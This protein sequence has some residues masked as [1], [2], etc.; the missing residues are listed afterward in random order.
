MAD[1]PPVIDADG[2][3]LERQSDIRKYLEPPWNRRNTGLWP[4]DQPFDTDL[5]DMLGYQGY[6][7]NMSPAQQVETWLKIMDEYN[8]E[9]AVL[10]PTGSGNIPK[11][12]EPEFCIAAC[13]AANDHFAKEYNAL[14]DR[15]H[16]VGV[17]PLKWPEEAAKELRRAV[18]Q[19]GLVSF[20]LLSMGL[21]TALGDPMYD[22]LYQEAERLDVPLSIHGNRSSSAEVGAVRTFAEVHCYT[23][24][25]GIFLHFTSMIFQGVPVRFPKL[26]LAFLE[27]GASWLPYWLD[28]MDEHWEL[29]GEFEAPHLKK[30]PSEVVRESPV[31]FSLEAE[32]RLLPQT[33]EYVGDDHFLYA[34]DV[35]H[36][37][38]EFPKNLKYLWNHPDLSRT[39]K[40]KIAYHN[41]KKYFSLDGAAHAVRKS[42]LSRTAL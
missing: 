33:I 8:I 1:W 41:G 21:P 3:V 17:L 36:W 25:V 30:K 7:R 13:R 32:E 12:R 22:P 10:F 37:D 40:E 27:I 4:S 18:T 16:C 29:R 24:P 31:Y 39:T 11:L 28:R 19:L 2:H 34:S 23:F 15:I 6:G 14:S 35:P 42:E 20:E 9:Q 26:R 5:F 38:G